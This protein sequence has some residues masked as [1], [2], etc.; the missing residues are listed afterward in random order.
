MRVCAITNVYNETFNLPIWLSYYGRELG[1]ENCIVVDHGSDRLDGLTAQSLVRTPRSPFDDGVRARTVTHLA[2]AMLEHYDVVLYTDCDEIL[3]PDPGAYAGLRDF[4]ERTEA[5]SHTAIGLEVLH[6]L[7]TEDPIDTTRLLLGQRA[8]CWFNSW[9]CKTSATRTPLQWSGGFHAASRAPNFDGLYLFHL[10]YLDH[11]ELL[12]RAAVTRDLPVVS[13]AVG[14]H[15]RDSDEEWTAR[16]ERKLHWEV[17]EGF[18]SLPDL[19]AETLGTVTVG[20]DG[21]FYFDATVRPKVLFRIPDRFKA[22]F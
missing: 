21:L 3:T 14:A 5:P 10:R 19:V 9:L 12:K 18:E 7:S 6:H 2:N 4:F 8:F 20:P 1:P 22:R 11:A 15:H 13:P 17:R 16:L